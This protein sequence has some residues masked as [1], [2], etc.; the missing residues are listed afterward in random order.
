MTELYVIAEKQIEQGDTTVPMRPQYQNMIDKSY[1]DFFER[2]DEAGGPTQTSDCGR[3]R[4]VRQ[5]PKPRCLTPHPENQIKKE[6]P[7]HI[8][9]FINENQKHANEKPLRVPKESLLDPII[10]NDYIEY[11]N[12]MP[13]ETF[14][15]KENTSDTIKSH[16]LY[17]NDDITIEDREQV[18]NLVNEYSD[19]FSKS[20]K[21]EAAILD[22]LI[23]KVNDELWSNRENARPARPQSEVTSKLKL[24]A[25]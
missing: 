11:K 19:I 12:D 1:S 2:K 10:D 21:E 9:N 18:Q 3:V 24:N 7:L 8:L 13:W 23:L 17:Y 6:D 20:L 5:H 22:P 25:R 14:L 4:G 15:K 16:P